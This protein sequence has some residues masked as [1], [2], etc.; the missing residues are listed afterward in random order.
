MKGNR[1]AGEPPAGPPAPDPVP[2]HPGFIVRREYL[3]RRNL[4]Q[5]EAA[6]RLGLSVR[7]LNELV[8]G[9]RRMTW[10]TAHRLEGQGVRTAKEWMD[11]QTAYDDWHQ[12]LDG[13]ANGSGGASAAP[14]D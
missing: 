14:P 8:C 4:S 5:R 6:R 3:E 11:L 1:S 12:H 9:K 2:E 13:G 10:C 7:T